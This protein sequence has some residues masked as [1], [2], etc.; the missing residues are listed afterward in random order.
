MNSGWCWIPTNQLTIKRNER[1]QLFDS[2]GNERAVVLKTEVP[3]AD[4]KSYAWPVWPYG[5]FENVGSA[6]TVI[7]ARIKA[8]RRLASCK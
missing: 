2:Y 6:Y 5:V 8:E 3:G 1:W 4:G 7:D